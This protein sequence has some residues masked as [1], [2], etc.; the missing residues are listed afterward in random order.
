MH[1]LLR[2]GVFGQEHDQDVSHDTRI[3]SITCGGQRGFWKLRHHLETSSSRPS[4][5]FIQEAT[6]D[7]RSFQIFY[8][9]FWDKLGYKTYCGLSE[10]YEYRGGCKGVITI[11]ACTTKSKRIHF[12]G[13]TRQ[14]FWL[15]VQMIYCWSIAMQRLFMMAHLSS[16]LR[17][18]WRKFLDPSTGPKALSLAVISIWR[19]W[20][21]V[22]RASRGPPLFIAWSKDT[23]ALRLGTWRQFLAV[24]AQVEYFSKDWPSIHQSP[25]KLS[26]YL[27]TVMSCSLFI[28][29]GLLVS[30]RSRARISL[31]EQEVALVWGLFIRKCSTKIVIGCSL[32]LRRFMGLLRCR[33]S[34]NLWIGRWPKERAALGN[35]LASQ[36]HMLT[37]WSPTTRLRV[38]TV[39]LNTSGLWRITG[40]TRPLVQECGGIPSCGLSPRLQKLRWIPRR[41]SSF[42]P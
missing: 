9:Q 3:W 29:E 21:L 17:S 18:P 14:P 41:R 39:V 12:C 25:R 35:S 13:T 19:H 36:M 42:P 32:A 16:S 31:G 30:R 5:L 4:I 22:W 28:W 24:L 33:S 38:I 11:V 23:S 15:Y 34:W 10:Q 20:P 6:G 27:T 8:S 2:G 26:G 40:P 37:H 7:G 1:C